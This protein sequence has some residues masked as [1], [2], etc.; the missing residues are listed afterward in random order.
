MSDMHRPLILAEI[1]NELESD[2]YQGDAVSS[3]FIEPP[4]AAGLSDEDSANEDEGGLIDNLS[5]RQLAANA[6]IVFTNDERYGYDVDSS[7]MTSD[8]AKDD[9][10]SSSTS[11]RKKT[12]SRR[13]PN[14]LPS[15][16]WTKNS[17]FS[18]PFDQTF[19]ESDFSKYSDFS[20]V[21]IFELF[22]DAELFHIMLDEIKNM[23]HSRIL[24]TK[25]HH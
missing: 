19:P 18:V 12:H 20:S 3:I 1:I 16:V 2:E 24:Q 8:P 5:S 22:F 7:H 10:A 14:S 15:R 25:Y 17:V 23:L 13:E 11:K 4:D 6:E 21:E 9:S